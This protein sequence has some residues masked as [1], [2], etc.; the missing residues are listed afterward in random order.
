MLGLLAWI[1]VQAQTI[2]PPTDN[3]PV[4]SPEPI[5]P[6]NAM[7]VAQ[8]GSLHT[9]NETTLTLAIFIFGAVAL[10]L[11]YLLVRIEKANPFVLRIYVITILI[12]GSLLVVANA[13]T[14]NQLA[15]VM[16]LFG[17]IAGYVLGRGDR[18]NEPH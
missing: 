9:L 2:P 1:G 4:K 17:T 14:T 11:L 18:P 5:T 10:W 16:G 7:D 8:V 15:P 3:L 6:G 13:Y 12:F